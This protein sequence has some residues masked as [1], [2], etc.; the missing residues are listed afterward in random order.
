MLL[1]FSI[2]APKIQPSLGHVSWQDKNAGSLYNLWRALFGI[3][4]ITTF[5]HGTQ[6]RLMEAQKFEHEISIA[7]KPGKIIFSKT[8]RII[9]VSLV[10]LI[11]L[12]Q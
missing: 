5:W 9:L 1:Y 3:F 4:H 2:L 6:V 7:D 11:P 10:L 8:S 12:L